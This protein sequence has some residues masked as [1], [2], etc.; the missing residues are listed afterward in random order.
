MLS[1][2][3]LPTR[4]I[5]PTKGS[6]LAKEKHPL[7]AGTAIFTTIFNVTHPA[8]KRY[9][10][11]WQETGV[12]PPAIAPAG[13]LAPAEPPSGHTIQTF[14][15]SKS[16]IEDNFESYPVLLFDVVQQFLKPCQNMCHGKSGHI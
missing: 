5:L 1:L 11:L 16:L 8:R 10:S 14:K 2:F 12:G 7:V 9:G 13:T 15:M 4:N 6:K 3:P